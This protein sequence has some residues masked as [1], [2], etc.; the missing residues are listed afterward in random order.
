MYK[1]S[2]CLHPYKTSPNVLSLFTKSILRSR[3]SFCYKR[4]AQDPSIGKC[5]MLYFY[6]NLIRISFFVVLF[7]LI[8]YLC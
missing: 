4:Y 5:M 3:I 1:L 7:I 6:T 8:P 2:F